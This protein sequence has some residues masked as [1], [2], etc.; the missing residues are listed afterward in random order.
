M[1]IR[2]HTDDGQAVQLTFAK[3][4]QVAAGVAG[5]LVTAVVIWAMSTLVS[6]DKRVTAI[7]SSR[8]THEDADGYVTVREYQAALASIMSQLN[9]IE[10]K[11]DR[12][13]I[14]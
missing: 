7:E 14:P 12:S 13:V 11:L 6:V 9:R 8:F 1:V 5:T 3:S 10:N 2:A 4:F